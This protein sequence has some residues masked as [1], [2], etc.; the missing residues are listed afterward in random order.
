MGEAK[1]RGS[2]EDRKLQAANEI[3]NSKPPLFSSYFA[4]DQYAS[5]H[6]AVADIITTSPHI[7]TMAWGGR[8]TWLTLN[9]RL[10]AVDRNVLGYVTDYMRG[11]PLNELKWVCVKALS[12]AV[13]LNGWR[14]GTMLADDITAFLE[15]KD[16]I[17][18]QEENNAI[19]TFKNLSHDTHIEIIENN[20]RVSTDLTEYP[21]DITEYHLFEPFYASMLGAYASLRN[22]KDVSPRQKFLNY[23]EWQSNYSFDLSTASF[24]MTAL[25]PHNEMTKMLK[26]VYTTDVAKLKKVVNNAARDAYFI[27]SLRANAALHP[28]YNAAAVSGDKGLIE[29]LNLFSLSPRDRKTPEEL[30]KE[31]WQ[32]D[33]SE[34]ITVYETFKQQAII[35]ESLKPSEYS[36]ME[37]NRL[38]LQLEKSLG[39]E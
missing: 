38:I 20:Y 34:I 25:A 31:S 32:G 30:I 22:N 16:D 5:M 23:I 14:S 28:E 36:P 39:I 13:A 15:G 17:F 12:A 6:S 26:S 1:R 37:L 18:R 11:K 27:G 4:T 21:Y 19:M 9:T 10:L 29:T 8:E 2:L 33:S 24:V 3:Q 7:I 35:V